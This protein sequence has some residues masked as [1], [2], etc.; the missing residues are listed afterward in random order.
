MPA[1]CVLS[2]PMPA[3]A[4]NAT[5]DTNRALDE[6]IHREGVVGHIVDANLTRVLKRGL[7]VSRIETLE[8]M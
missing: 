6:D 4:L 7:D 1:Q 2:T 5:S 3:R 8:Q